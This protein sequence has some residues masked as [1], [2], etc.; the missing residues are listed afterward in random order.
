[1]TTEAQDNLATL[2]EDSSGSGDVAFRLAE[3]T[4][5]NYLPLK[6]PIYG[7]GHDYLVTKRNKI[8]VPR[9]RSSISNGGKLKQNPSINAASRKDEFTKN[10][11]HTANQ[12]F[13]GRD[14]S[15]NK[16]IKP[17]IMKYAI[18]QFKMRPS[19]GMKL[20]CQI[21]RKTV[22][23]NGTL[24]FLGHIPNLPKRS[25]LLVAGLKVE[26]PEDLATDGTFFG[27]RYFT[28]PPKQAYFLPFKSCQER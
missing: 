23:L 10:V 12:L 5:L 2:E 11:I 8:M 7:R 18:D 20:R 28:T 24:Q 22:P 27:K 9:P 21:P 15:S 19:I 17:A 13:T 26:T 1:M 6:W 14:M 4:G 25:D 3:S 16:L